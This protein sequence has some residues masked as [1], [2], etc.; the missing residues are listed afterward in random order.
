MAPAERQRETKCPPRPLPAP[1]GTPPL[2]LKSIEGVLHDLI[3]S[4]LLPQEK[5]PRARQLLDHAFF[6][7]LWGKGPRPQASPQRLPAPPHPG[8]VVLLLLPTAPI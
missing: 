4:C 2:A 6:D 8:S 7:T 1:Q 5:R 3:A